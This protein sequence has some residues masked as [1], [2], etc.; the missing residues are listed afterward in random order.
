MKKM[1]DFYLSMG[2]VDEN[3]INELSPGLLRSSMESS[4]AHRK[5]LLKEGL[6]GSKPRKKLFKESVKAQNLEGVVE[7]GL[8]FE[9]FSINGWF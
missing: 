4:G 2:L 7:R 8:E 6:E 3:F 9:I 5:G 1:P